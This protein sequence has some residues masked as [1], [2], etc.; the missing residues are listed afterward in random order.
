MVTWLRIIVSCFC[1]VLCVLFAALWARGFFLTDVVTSLDLKQDWNST[2]Q[3]GRGLLLYQQVTHTGSRLERF[4]EINP[5][6]I[7]QGQTNYRKWITV[8]G[9]VV[10]EPKNTFL[11]ISYCAS[12]SWDGTR[13]LGWSFPHWMIVG[14]CGLIATVAK[15]RPRWKFGMR[16]LLVLLT[17]GTCTVGSLAVFLRAI[18]S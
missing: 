14:T 1:L 15:S 17:V 7:P 12:T 8:K 2:F 6:L 10:P 18:N 16:E 4:I 5:E 3:I 13:Y 9:T 11:R